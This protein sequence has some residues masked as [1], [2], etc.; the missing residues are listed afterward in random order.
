MEAEEAGPTNLLNKMLVWEH[1]VK[2]TVVLQVSITIVVVVAVGGI[3][4]VRAVQ[5]APAS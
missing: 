3:V 5:A 2:A 4:T 1:L